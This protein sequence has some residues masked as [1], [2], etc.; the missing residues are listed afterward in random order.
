MA[1]P[2]MRIEPPEPGEAPR[3]ARELMG[4]E[5]DLDLRI[6]FDLLGAPKRYSELQPLLGDR[7]DHNLTVALERLQDRGLVT[8][9]TDA[10]ED[11]PTHT[12]QV[13]ELGVQTALHVH[14]SRVIDEAQGRMAGGGT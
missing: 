14:T 2:E 6:L 7:G 10:R 9:Q 12:Y 4:K 1:G 13:T 3:Q 8:R 11:P 5:S